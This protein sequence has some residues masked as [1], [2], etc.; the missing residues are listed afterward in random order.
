MKN[1]FFDI[2]ADYYQIYLHDQSAT[3]DL[4]QAWNKQNLANRYFHDD[5]VIAIAT[6][7][8]MNVPIE[9]IINDHEAH[10]DDSQWEHIILTSITFISDTMILRGPSDYLP[11]AQ[12]INIK[13]GHYDACILINGLDT[14]S[15][16]GLDGDD[17]YKIILWPS[18]KA[19]NFVLKRK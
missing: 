15:D 9:V 16:D 3:P 6:A 13:P 18:N 5:G 11:D 14:I 4:S 8:N 10:I 17:Y 19:K 7:R 12:R 2:F 1:Y